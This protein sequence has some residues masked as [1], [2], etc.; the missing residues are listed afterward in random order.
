M[1]YYNQKEKRK[2]DKKMKREQYYKSKATGKTT[3]SQRE[4]MEWYRAKE[5][6]EVWYFSE[7]IGEWLCGIEWVL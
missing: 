1:L 3:T 7:A 6:I 5:E 4:A 2:G